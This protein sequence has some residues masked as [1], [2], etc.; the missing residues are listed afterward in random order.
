MTLTAMQL[1]PDLV[2]GEFLA[3]TLVAMTMPAA[4]AAI[5]VWPGV[6]KRPPSDV[7]TQCFRCGARSCAVRRHAR[8]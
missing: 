5:A 2:L 3:I 1:T 7:M 4:C 6:G 8:A